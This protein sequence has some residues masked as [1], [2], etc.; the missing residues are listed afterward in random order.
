MVQKSNNILWSKLAK[1]VWRCEKDVYICGIY[2]PPH[3]SPHFNSDIFDQL[4]NDI[5]NYTTKGF[6]LLLGDFSAR[7]GKYVDTVS[8]D[9]TITLKMTDQKFL[10]IRLTEI[11]ST[12][13]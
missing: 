1:E 12:T 4:E 13:L 7:T 2:I 9:G 8:K 10:Y 6:V 5:T 3:N 11:V